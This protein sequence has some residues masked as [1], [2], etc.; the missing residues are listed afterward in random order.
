MPTQRNPNPGDCQFCLRLHVPHVPECKARCQV[1][2]EKV[3]KVAQK[4]ASSGGKNINVV[5]L[6]RH[7]NYGLPLCIHKSQLE[8]HCTASLARPH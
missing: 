6:S 7:F 4:K 8:V 3:L 5:L 2:V 1:S